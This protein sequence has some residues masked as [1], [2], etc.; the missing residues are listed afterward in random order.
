MNPDLCIRCRGIKNLCGLKSCPLL[1][2]TNILPRIAE[3]YSGISPPAIFI[4]RYNYPRVMVSTLSSDFNVPENLYPLKLD[5]ILLYRTS[6]YRVGNVQ[7]VD[8]QSKMIDRI[9]EIS[10]SSSSIGINAEVHKIERALDIN[11]ISTP[12]GPRIIAGSIDLVNEPKVP[13]RID[14]LHND[15]D[16]NALS[17]VWEIYNHG[18][19]NEYI[20]RLLSGGALGKK[21]DRRL[22]PT[23]WAITAVDDIIGK[24]LIE[25]VREY[26]PLESIIYAENEYMWNKFHILFLPGPWS[27]EMIEN[28]YGQNYFDTNVIKSSDY[29]KFEGRKKYAEIVGGSYYAA[30]LAVLEFLDRI[31][32]QSSV[33]VYRTIDS[34]YKIPLGVWVIRETVRDAMKKVTILSEKNIMDMNMDEN[35][36]KILLKSRTSLNLYAQRRIDSYE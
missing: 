29:E 19:S 5:D 2:Y 31:Q 4:G 12:M 32:K 6:L 28:W 30:R 23:R 10:L 33:I 3:V 25:K 15:Y 36:K 11:H 34:D 13:K 24:K 22:V 35:L 9:K 7:R 17:A 16:L 14:T 27:F 21:I 26:E 1:K 20:T 18:F 8:R